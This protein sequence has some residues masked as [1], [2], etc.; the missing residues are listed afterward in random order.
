MGERKLFEKS[1]SFPHTPYLSKTFKR[2]YFFSL[3]SAFKFCFD[4]SNSFRE[5]DIF[6]YIK[7]IFSI[8]GEAN[9]LPFESN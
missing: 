7:D 2:G 6:P 4:K 9:S 3:H 1:F 5:D 8:V